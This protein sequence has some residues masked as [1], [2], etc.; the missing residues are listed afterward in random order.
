MKKTEMIEFQWISGEKSGYAD[1]PISRQFNRWYDNKYE[2]L[3]INNNVFEREDGETVETMYIV[4][5]YYE[6]QEKSN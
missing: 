1:D 2:I 4:Y 5:T 3:F 6:P